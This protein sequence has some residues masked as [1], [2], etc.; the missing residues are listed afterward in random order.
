MAYLRGFGKT[1]AVA[2]YAEEEAADALLELEIL[3]EFA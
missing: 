1:D 2:R 3:A